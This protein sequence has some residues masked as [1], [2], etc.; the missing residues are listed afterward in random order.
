MESKSTTYSKRVILRLT[1][2]ESE[3]NYFFVDFFVEDSKASRRFK[4]SVKISAI[5]GGL[6]ILKVIIIYLALLG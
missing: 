2:S 5:V 3:I 4:I 6:G 1:Y